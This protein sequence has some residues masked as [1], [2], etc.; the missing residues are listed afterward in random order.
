M[1]YGTKRKGWFP[2]ARRFSD[3][4]G[5]ASNYPMAYVYAIF[6]AVSGH[7]I[8]R[9][10]YLRYA[11]NLYPNH[12]VCLVGDS[13]I[14]HK[15][16]AINVG[17]EAMGDE[18]LA[19]HP[20]IRSVTTT[21]GLLVAMDNGGGSAL[22]TLD[23]MASLLSKKKQD[24]A[25]DL[26]S[27]IV[28]LYGCPKVAGTY[29][30]HDPIEVYDTF[31]TMV[32]AST[33][34][35]LQTGLTSNDMMAGFGNRM[36]FVLGDPRPERDWPAPP[37][38]EAIDFSALE[39]YNGE[40]VLDEQA[41]DMWTDFYHQFQQ[42]QKRS[43]SFIRVLAE[44]I[45]EK[46]LKNCIVQAA[47]LGTMVVS[48]TMLRAAIDWGTYLYDCIEALVPSFEHAE[49]QVLA[50]IK[51]GANSRRKLYGRLGH[52]MSAEQIK[53]AI[54]ALVWLGEIEEDRV[55]GVLTPG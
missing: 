44:R 37:D 54:A 17:L 39:E 33:V 22:I 51:K 42:K 11:S 31:V 13:G 27:R 1:D 8:G 32:G 36:T 4:V 3:A 19:D 16:T 45:P 15:S 26:L 47:W 10:A 30:R 49:A 14:H 55:S 52:N 50:E 12:Y 9:N 2:A 40:V 5:H 41:R 38:L 34:E 48:N 24:F 46:V 25:S 29:T 28:E 6:L 35:W 23:E 20:P 43:S 21:Q 7:V 53:R 18:L